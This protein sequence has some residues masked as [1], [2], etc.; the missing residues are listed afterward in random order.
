MKNTI[1][2]KMSKLIV[3]IMVLSMIIAGVVSTLFMD[4]YYKS[5]KQKA[6]KQIYDCLDNTVSKDLFIESQNSLEDLDEICEKNGASLI[7]IDSSGTPIYEYGGAKMLFDRWRDV[8]F[9]AHMDDGTVTEIIEQNEQYT[10]QHT[11]ELI[12]SNKYYELSGVLQGNYYFIAR[13]SVESFR[14]SINISNKFYLGL[15]IGL[16]IVITIT[17]IMVTRKFTKP[18]YQLADISRR[19][20]NLDFNVRYTGKRDDEIDVLGT[21]MNELSE[22][23]EKTITELKVANIELHKDIQKKEEVDEMRKEFISNVSHE[24]KTPIALIQGYAEGLQDGV[25]DDPEDMKY[26]CEVIIDEAEKMNKMVKNLLALNQ[27]EF[28]HNELN[29]QR[30]DIVSVVN[31]IIKN[32]RIQAE[33]ETVEISFNMDKPI[34][35]WA[36]EFQIEQVITNYLSNAFNHV[37]ENKRIEV[38]IIENNGI[39]RV[40]V[41]NTGKNIPEE[42]LENIWIKFYKVDKARTREYGGNGIGL[43]VVKAIMD[44]HHKK[45]GVK[46]YKEGVEF[47]FELDSNSLEK[48][49][50]DD[51]NN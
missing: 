21:S 37:D 35:V 25:I 23:L 2:Y 28:G 44:R 22:K 15:G 43:S 51:S 1:G 49:T 38:K 8:M 32:F 48:G 36:D 41:F 26:Y 17:I 12:S 47:Y 16:L 27:L 40:S 19:M 24:L 50:I 34:F 29:I 39:V 46:N 5:T 33:Q 31:E 30:F 9:G 42:E 11:E 14:E 3:A 7:V 18:I 10:L 20:S 4:K 45:Y 13:M 6:I